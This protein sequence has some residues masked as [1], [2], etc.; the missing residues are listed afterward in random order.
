MGV[1]PGDEKDPTAELKCQPPLCHL[2]LPP[3]YQRSPCR[4]PG[5]WGISLDKRGRMG[6]A[7]N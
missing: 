5:M 4:L 6:D 2:L 1:S 3:Q 7:L